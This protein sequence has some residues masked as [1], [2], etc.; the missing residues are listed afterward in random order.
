GMPISDNTV[1]RQLKRNVPSA[2][3]PDDVRVLG[4]DDW[5]WRRSSHY[6]TIMVDL[7]KRSAVDIL[8]D[9]SVESVKT[10]LQKRP[11]I[12]VVSRDRCG[13]YAPGCRRRASKDHA[14]QGWDG[15]QMAKQ[16]YLYILCQCTIC[17]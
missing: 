14:A 2:A 8:D 16:V 13:L 10:G 11:T 3:Q 7:E 1:L 6:G 15:S 5:S 17:L 9:R 12:E 4:I